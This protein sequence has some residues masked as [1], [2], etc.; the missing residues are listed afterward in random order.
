ML[1]AA[2]AAAAASSPIVITEAGA[3][4]G[5]TQGEIAVYRGVPFA[6]APVGI[7][8]WQPPIAPAAWTGTR[9]AQAFEPA[10]MQEGVSMPG[11][12]PPATSEDCLYLNLWAPRRH[13][14]AGLPVLVW[15]YG[16]GYRNGS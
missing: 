10:C 8:R 16:G 13:T 3:I 11:E 2:S 15:I 4:S 7:L 12:T 14:K 9:A 5:V 6:A 1:A